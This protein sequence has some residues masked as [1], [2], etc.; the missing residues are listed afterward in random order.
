MAGA[1]SKVKPPAPILYSGLNVGTSQFDLPVPV[2][3]GQRRLGF[4]ALG[5]D[6]FKQH[7][8]SSKGKGGGSKTGKQY[9]YSAEIGLGLCEGPITAIPG[10]W[11]NGSTTTSTTLGALQFTLM[12]GTATQAP[13]SGGGV[14]FATMAYAYTC[15]VYC[16][17]L[18]LGDSASIPQD[19]FECVAPRGFAYT[20]ESPGWINPN[21]HVQSNAIDVLMSDVI[22]DILTNPQYGILGFSGGDFGD[23][24]QYA[25]Y[26]RAQGIVVSPLL[27]QLEKATSVID[28]WAEI[29][30]SWIFWS[31]T[32]F[33]F[34]PLGDE[35]LSANGADFSPQNEVAYNLTLDHFIGD[36]NP[37]KVTRKD[38]ADCFNRTVLNITDR[39]L[40]YI[41]NP[42][43]FKEQTLI[44]QYGMRDNENVQADEI[45]NP[46]VARI[47]VNLLGQRAAYIRNTYAF[48]TS[49]RFIL[50]LPGTILTLTEPNI[51]LNLT[52]V[53]VTKISEDKDGVL[54]FECEEYPGTVGNFIPHDYGGAPSPTTPDQNVNPGSVNVPAIV[55]T[56]LALT[57]GNP[58]ILVAASGGA[59]W[60]GCIVNVSFDSVTYSA[61]GTINAPATQGLLTASLAAFGGANPDT[62]S[63]LN[64][65]CS[66]SLGSPVPVSV[67]DATNLRTLSLVVAAS[68]E[69]GGV[70]VMPD[71]GE[72]LAFGAVTPTGTYTADLT[73]LERA[74]F[75]TPG[76]AAVIGAQ[77]TLLNVNWGP[78][79]G[80]S[81]DGTNLM[82]D[83]P[84]QY[85]GVPIY[86]K[87]QSY[88]LF[89]NALQ[90]LS[91]CIAY[92]YTPGGK[93][94]QEPLAGQWTATAIDHAAGTGAIP[95]PAIEFTGSASDNPNATT[96]IFYGSTDGTNYNVL[97]TI[98]AS[99]TSASAFFTNVSPNTL[100]Y[101][102]VAYEI[103][104]VVGPA[105]I[106]GTVTTPL[107]TVGTGNINPHAVTQPIAILTGAT[108]VLTAG[109]NT[110]VQSVNITTNGGLVAVKGNAIYV[111]GN[112]LNPPPTAIGL[113]RD[114]FELLGVGF[115]YNQTLMY[116]D[117][118]LPGAHTYTLNMQGGNANITVG[119]CYLE[120]IELLR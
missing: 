99:K 101:V 86:L 103:M 26:L 14:A 109:V 27:N 16:P 62:T 64:V 63:S 42:F 65:D 119:D 73:Y 40:G 20:P 58:E 33:E 71:N 43:E 74:Q 56:P 11:A 87:F 4:N 29:T 37:V 75:G 115:V 93:G 82:F 22:V 17:Q 48:K 47:V 8:V 108:V 6:N 120:A 70:Y 111:S 96:V 38:P 55:T 30:N 76:D 18:D 80:L 104:S 72:L 32:Q 41:S 35:T 50:C 19:E 94:I 77:F 44:D 89:G 39:T 118:P 107:P 3:W 51:G 23:M 57:S 60:G 84:S 7:N 36:E 5:F 88:N 97:G 54:S 45:C 59:F 102:A 90:D 112:V 113:Y 114:G 52:P 116:L 13:I 110:V 105:L 91:T 81:T 31:G 25:S 92:E 12:T 9:N 117:N 66:E 106:L 98:P 49:Y 69:S 100:Y 1:Q 10:I 34:V 79:G 28:R 46:T 83:L 2:F 15:Y 78:G 24:T 85:M 21:N 95:V 53:R 61:V 68:V 67:A